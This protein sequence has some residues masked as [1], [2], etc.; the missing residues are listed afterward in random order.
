MKK[1][2]TVFCL[3]ISVMI[4]AQDFHFSQFNENPAL[5]NPALV[6]SLYAFRASAVY[7][8]QWKSVTNAYNTYGVNVEMKFKPSNW[9][10]VDPK[11]SLIFKKSYNRIAGGLS[12]FNDKAGDS[13]MGTL[14]ALLSIATFVPLNKNNSLSVGLQGSFVQRKMNSSKL[15]YPNQYNG[16]N[17]DPNLSSGET[18]NSQS[19]S[20]PDFGAGLSWTYNQE[21]KSIAANNQTRAQIGFSMFH[22]NQPK[23]RYLS[24]NERL[25]MK[26]VFHGNILIGIPNSYFGIAPSWLFQFQGPSKELMAG[27]M[28]KYYIKDD[29]RYTGFIKRSSIGIGAYYRNSD[30]LIASVLIETGRYAIGLS[31]DINLSGLTKVSKAQGGP[32]I[33]LRF[34][35]PNAFLYQKKSRGIF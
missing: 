15:I 3:T 35:T 24:N 12:V 22:V 21:E 34:N 5:I 11:R 6:G 9:E 33:T 13:N 17:Y 29:S 19:F 4:Q 26:Y 18:Y 31:Y 30:A 16:Y 8:D 28:F 32:E 7:K 2:I 1:I 14:Q 20:Y 10:V 23:L 27:I 25:F